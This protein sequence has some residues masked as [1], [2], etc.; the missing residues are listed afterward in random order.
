MSEHVPIRPREDR[1][2]ALRERVSQQILSAAAHVLAVNGERASMHDVAAAAGIARGTLYRY[3]PSRHT[4]V[5]RLCESA[6]AEAAAR[7]GA[8]RVA[9][10]DPLEG[11][12]R[13]IRVFVEI[14]DA[15]VVAAR[16]RG[17]PEGEPF[18]AVVLPPLRA[19]VERAQAAGVVRD[20][21][22]VAWLS[23]SL[24]GMLVAAASTSSLGKEDLIASVRRLFLEGARAR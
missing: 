8:S 10:V 14:G 21:M 17:R 2:L 19:V 13:T 9:E 15:F 24:L 11:L 23:E 20:D 4:L 16:E 5:D 18:D 3:F 7:L 6:A 12:E 22:S 1:R